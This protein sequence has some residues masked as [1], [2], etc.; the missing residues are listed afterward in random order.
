[1]PVD[2]T[3]RAVF[4]IAATAILQVGHLQQPVNTSIRPMD[5]AVFAIAA[6]AILQVGHC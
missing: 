1:M 2:S 6:T 4:A 3:D 5:R